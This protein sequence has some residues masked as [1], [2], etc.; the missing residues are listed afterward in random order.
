MA[1]L[2]CPEEDVCNS[3]YLGLTPIPVLYI[4]KDSSHFHHTVA[5]AV[6]APSLHNTLA[7]VYIPDIKDC[8][9]VLDLLSNH[10]IEL[11]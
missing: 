10:H 3:M 9:F 4:I 11:L 6:A 8:V 5:S 7:L 2:D 1:M